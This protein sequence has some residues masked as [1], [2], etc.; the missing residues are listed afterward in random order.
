MVDYRGIL[1]SL[2]LTH[3]NHPIDSGP[4]AL[5][6][7]GHSRA[8][9]SRLFKRR[10][11]VGKTS[12]SLSSLRE[13]VFGEIVASPDGTVNTAHVEGVDLDLIIKPFGR[14]GTVKTVRDFTI[15]AAQ[16][17]FGMQVEKL[18]RVHV[19]LDADSITA[20]VKV[21]TRLWGTLVRAP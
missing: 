12:P 20:L 15:G 3:G 8:F 18:G 7:A 9:R 14:E 10:R 4:P 6:N 5:D 21:R 1:P 16:L 11:R 13:V 19:A 2:Q 17:H